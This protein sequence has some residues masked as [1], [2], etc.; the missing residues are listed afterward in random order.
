MLTERDLK[1]LAKAFAD[2]RV[3]TVYLHPAV[4]NPADRHRWEAEFEQAVRVVLDATA[5]A[6]HAEREAARAAVESVRRAL[7][8]PDAPLDAAGILAVADE[9]RLAYFVP[10]E[11]R[12]P[13]V[14]AWQQ[15]VLLAPLLGEVTAAQPT[16]LL[17][18][19]ERTARLYRV[20][21]PRQLELLQ[22]RT[23]LQPS[24][25]ERH[26]GSSKGRF[27][28]GTRGGTAA[29][30]LDRQQRAARDRLFADVLVPALDLMGAQGWLAI[31]GPPR[32]VAAARALV[33]DTAEDRVIALDGLD[34]HAT[35]HEMVQAV[36]T[37]LLARIGE[38]D[39][40]MM[41]GLLDAAAAR[42]RAATGLVATRAMLERED[43]A[44]L[45]L[46]DAFVA[47]HPT[48]TD[49][50]LHHAF[51]QG[52]HVHEVHGAAAATIDARAEGIVARLRYAMP[53]PLR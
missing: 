32:A 25:V 34:A 19:D 36:A 41:L 48:E 29:D 43:V 40:A 50:L 14:A 33:P 27:H 17:M 12:V 49:D 23:A 37:A 15:G 1:Q 31:G 16:V 47:R 18:V 2:R 51:R 3:L 28:T 11:T 8:Q 24:E 42:G 6:P 26:L 46:S 13:S 22:T 21:L 9:R 44:D 30:A 38:R 39:A 5:T 7:A 10:L 35:S 4:D 53:T 20:T 52:A 45:F